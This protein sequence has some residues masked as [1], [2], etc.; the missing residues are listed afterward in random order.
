MNLVESANMFFG[1]D[2]DLDTEVLGMLEE[3]TKD[4][5]VKNPGEEKLKE[6][7]WKEK[8]IGELV[9]HF[10]AL[11]H[12]KGK[13]PVMRSILNIERWNESKNEALSKKARSVIN[14]LEKNK[15]WENM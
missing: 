11:A 2:D 5:K 1:N 9:K 10:I 3:G 6:G 12:K 4:I 7:A 15:T 8:T 13:A 14:K